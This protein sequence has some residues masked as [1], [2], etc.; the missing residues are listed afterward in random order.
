MPTRVVVQAQSAR[1]E[2]RGA[3]G[4]LDLACRGAPGVPEPARRASATWRSPA[5]SRSCS[6][7]RRGYIYQDGG[8][9][10]P[11]GHCRPFDARRQGTVRRQRRRRGRASAPRGCDRG[12]R[13]DRAVISGP[14]INND[15]A[16]KVGFTAPSVEGQAD[17]IAM[18][19]AVAGVDADD[20]SSYVEAH[21]TATPLGDPIEV[22]AL[23]RVFR[24]PDDAAG[25][26]ALGSVK[27][28]IGHLD[29]AAGVA[30]LIKAV[31]ARRAGPSAAHA[32]LHANRTRRST[33][34]SDAFL[35]ATLTC[36]DWPAGG[37]PRRAGV[38]SF[39]IGGTN[40]HLI[41]EQ[42]PARRLSGRSRSW[43]MLALSA[44]TLPALDT[45][46]DAL[47]DALCEAPEAP[48]ADTAYTLLMGRKA[49]E[50]RRVIV[51]GSVS[52]ALD[53]L[54]TDDPARLFTGIASASARPVTL[55]FPGQGSQHVDMARELYEQE[56]VF[57]AELDRCASILRSTVGLDLPAVLF[58]LPADRERSAERLDRTDLCQLALFSVEF[59]LARFVTSLG[60]QVQSYIGHSLGEYVAACLAGV[61]TLE[62][63]LGVVADRG[64]LMAE[65]PPG[66]MLAVSASE[67][68]VKSWMNPGRLSMAVVNGPAACVV[69]GPAAAVSELAAAL[70]DRGVLHRR[71]HV[72]HAFHS[73]V[74]D[75][76]LPAF[77]AVMSRVPLRPPQT[78]F[79][80]NVT[81]TWIRSDEATD[82][83]TGAV[84]F[85]EPSILPMGS[86][87][88]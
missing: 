28:N 39:G 3:D 43:Q 61:F 22:A 1:A 52:D 31:L 70:D 84:S 82:P 68:Q 40:A 45:A 71:L 83:D 33:L 29:A 75:A 54:D 85:A 16:V 24:A 6:V 67:T 30:G 4:V 59:A 51:C 58:P 66:D 7:R 46:T 74:M 55:M 37:T 64:R 57:R 72:S 41:L 26:C 32:A 53:A 10:S 88:C 79:I 8:I 13:R 34:A 69:A 78:P 49:F 81:G 5:A 21:G 42:A 80:S 15:G 47:A 20:A 76:A 14:A 23:T 11:D 9:L 87:R 27:S 18:A 60:V 48:L 12:R 56:P 77:R 35:R 50:H 38:S 17:V 73:H 19:Q 62:D 25:F 63:A 65:M 2:R 86:E 44:R 36:V